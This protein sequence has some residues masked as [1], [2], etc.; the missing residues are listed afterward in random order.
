MP[1]FSPDGTRVA[2]L[3]TADAAGRDPVDVYVVR[4]DGSGLQRITPRHPPDWQWLGWTPDGRQLVV[5]PP[6][7]SVTRA[8]RPICHVNQLDLYDATG[9]GAVQHLARADGMDFVQ[10]RPPDGGRAPLPGARRREMGPV[11]DGPG[12]LEPAARSRSRRS[13]RRSI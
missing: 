13:R 8:R 10:F 4:A 6:A 11:R 9:S 7:E 12:R 1:Q 2:F 5:I 3:Q